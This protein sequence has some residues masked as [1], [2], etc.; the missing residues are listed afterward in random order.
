MLTEYDAVV[1][2]LNEHIEALKWEIRELKDERRDIISD[3]EM[4][5]ECR[6]YSDVV[7]ELHIARQQLASLEH[8]KD[9]LEERVRDLLQMDA[10]GLL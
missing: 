3:P 2:V 1:V 6:E 8:F 4:G 9:C 10:M 7:K 5:R